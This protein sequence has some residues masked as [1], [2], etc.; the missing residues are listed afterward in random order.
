MSARVNI[1]Q[2]Q[3]EMSRPLRIMARPFIDNAVK[4]KMRF[5]KQDLM[6]KF[7]LHK[8]TREL[9][10]GPTADNISETIEGGGNLFSFIGFFENESPTADLAILLNDSVNLEESPPIIRETKHQILYTYGVSTPS[11]REID[12]NTKT[13]WGGR[14]WALG[15]EDGTI[16]GIGQY[17]YHEFFSPKRSRSTTGVQIKMPGYSSGLIFRPIGY[18]LELLKKFKKRLKSA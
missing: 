2:V 3:Q 11:R 9:N 14:G 13:H 17:L 5:A 12:E 7:F 10:D 4:T 16:T 15:I 6:E 1:R 18:V 8:V